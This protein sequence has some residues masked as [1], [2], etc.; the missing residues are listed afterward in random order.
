MMVHPFYIIT[1]ITGKTEHKTEQLVIHQCEKMFLRGHKLSME[2]ST[3]LQ[4][5]PTYEE[6][7][8]PAFCFPGIVHSTCRH[9]TKSYGAFS[10]ESLLELVD[11]LSFPSQV[12]SILFSV[13]VSFTDIVCCPKGEYFVCMQ[14]EGSNHLLF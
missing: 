3:Q 10:L 11:F 8:M 9:A 7:M 12:K 2:K 6:N 14:Q 1:A 13:P 5:L 4:F